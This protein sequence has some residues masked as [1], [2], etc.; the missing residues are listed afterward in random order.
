MNAIFYK[1]EDVTITF[2]SE[3]D[4]S[5]YTKVVKFF[6][7]NSVI[8]SATVTAINA[9]AFSVKLAATDTAEL[10]IGELNIVVEFTA[11]GNKMISKTIQCSIADAYL[12]GSERGAVDLNADIVFMQNMTMSV[13]IIGSSYAAEAA[14]SAADAIEAK[15]I[16][17]ESALSAQDGASYVSS[18][19][20][21]QTNL[22]NRINTG[23]NSATPQ[24]FPAHG[25]VGLNLKTEQ[26]ADTFSPLRLWGKGFIRQFS[27]I[28]ASGSTNDTTNINYGTQANRPSRIELA[29]WVNDAQ[30]A[31]MFDTRTFALNIFVITGGRNITDFVN[32]IKVVGNK[33]TQ[34]DSTT[35][36]AFTNSN[37]MQ[38]E[39]LYKYMGWT[40]I[41]LRIFNIS[42]VSST[43]TT[44]PIWIS[45]LNPSYLSG[46]SFYFA[47]LELTH[48]DT[49]IV[50]SLYNYPSV[51]GNLK[52][53]IGLAQEMSQ[54]ES[55]IYDVQVKT[56]ANTLQVAGLQVGKVYNECLYDV[57]AGSMR[58]YYSPTYDLVV[59]VDKIC[60]TYCKLLTKTEA[61][62]ATGIVITGGTDDAGPIFL[63]NNITIGA[64]HGLDCGEVT[65]VGHGKTVNDVGSLWV[66]SAGIQHYILEVVSTSIFRT[67][68]INY[69]TS[70]APTF[71]RV[72]AGSF[73]HVSG[74]VH[75]GAITIASVVTY[76]YSTKKN[77]TYKAYAD[78][79]LLS[80]NSATFKCVN[81]VL[82]GAYEISDPLDMIAKLVA[83]KPVGGYTVQPDLAQGNSML[84]VTTTQTLTDGGSVVLDQEIE[85]FKDLSIN[86]WGMTQVVFFNP[87]KTVGNALYSAGASNTYKRFIPKSLPINL[88]YGS[89]SDLR[90]G[91]NF[92][93]TQPA[94][95][96]LTSSYW[97]NPLMPPDRSI[98]VI[99]NS[100]GFKA[101]FTVTYLPYGSG[102]TKRKDNIDDAWYLFSSKKNYPKAITGKINVGGVLPS[103]TYKQGVLQRKWTNLIGESNHT[104][105]YFAEHVN[106]VYLYADYHTICNDAIAV[107]FKYRGRTIEVIEKSSNVEVLSD[108][109]TDT[110]RVKVTTASPL[111]GYV[112]LKLK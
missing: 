27:I 26:I 23:E 4:M 68:S 9:K 52:F 11:S 51:D 69:G 3:T 1:G 111:Y 21:D 12:S 19:V 66:D 104:V 22:P 103:G 32:F 67:L 81:L 73:T 107:P 95:A 14:A 53:P 7:P 58:S 61:I 108:V 112:V 82:I 54:L 62:G 90:L 17:V 110:I 86:W 87:V 42:W 20:N 47:N 64:N 55:S 97:E 77:I 34:V 94:D 8:K 37:S 79:V 96:N 101:A 98:D 56:A 70:S 74:A 13:N 36:N 85:T 40:K 2:T 15:E 35:T 76:A 78:G 60:N 92:E 65:C 38:Y 102:G 106:D 18:I 91:V 16:A 88:G 80:E 100:N 6:T 33:T 71:T 30:V 105:A 93:G 48:N 43:A 5:T 50:G 39:V 63:N 83:N 46:K 99:D 89:N 44:F 28:G 10:T 45:F 59:K 41:V 72:V 49:Q 75:T 29:F 109:A 25:D 31:E 57:A 84:K 24:L